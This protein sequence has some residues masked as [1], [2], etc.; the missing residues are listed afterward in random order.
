LKSTTSTAIRPI[1]DGTI[2]ANVRAPRISGILARIR[3]TPLDSR[4]FLNTRINGGLAFLT[5]K[6]ESI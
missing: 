1:I 5:I 4:E 6:K 2:Y 3:K